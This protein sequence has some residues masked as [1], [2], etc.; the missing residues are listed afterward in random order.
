VRARVVID[1]T[2]EAD[3]A[4]RAGVPILLPSNTREYDSHSPTGMGIWAMVAGVDRA[5]LDTKKG[6]RLGAKKV[7]IA[8]LAQIT[9]G[10]DDVGPE[11]HLL[12][13]KA[14]LVRPHVKVDA[15]NAEHISL[16]EAGARMYIF[17][18][19][20]R[21]RREVEGCEHAYVLFIAPFFGARGGPCIEGEYTLTVHDLRA[22]K[23]FDD[24]IYVYGEPRAL[25][26]TLAHG[27]LKS[28]WVGHPPT[29]ASPASKP[30]W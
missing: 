3:V 12:G 5:N 9:A 17:E 7:G 19:V 21:L 13:I 30:A 27:E 26:W 20:Q 18:Y 2:G 14:Q 15:G 1:A 28:T 4:R 25:R 23:L 6:E 11:P 10:L 8:G 24:V 29:P 22:G 16:L